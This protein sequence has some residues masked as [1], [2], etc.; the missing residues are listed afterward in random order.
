[1]VASIGATALAAVAAAASS[2]ACAAIVAGRT[3]T[4][5]SVSDSGAA[6]YTIP[7]WSPPGVGDVQLNLGLTYNSRNPNSV[8]GMGWSI[9]GLS[10]ITRCNKT[11]AQDGAPQ[12][13][14]LTMADRFCLDGQQLKL[15]SASGTYGQAGSTYATEIE[16]FAKIV[17]NSASGNGPASFTVITKNGL[18]YEYGSTLDSQIKPGGGAT[19]RTWA[20]SQIHDRVGTYGNRISFT[21]TNETTN[22]TYRIASITYPTTAS[23]Q[24]PFYEV[25]FTYVTNPASN[26]PLSYASGFFS[27]EPKRLTTIT[28]KNFGSSTPTK[29][30][31]LGYNIGTVTNRARLNSIQECSATNCLPATTIAYQ[32]G[33]PG[34]STT[35]GNTGVTTSTAIGVNPI[36]IDLNGD[37]LMDLL[38]P[39]VQTSTTSRWWA[40]QKWTRFLGQFPRSG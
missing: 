35:L 37:G 7:L 21:Y 27:R 13:V 38:Y 24:G 3:P 16:T 39:K 20:L 11:W 40:T 36:P 8:L 34:W 29:R 14:L 30:Y 25:G 9:S 19:I 17:A 22:N 32:D 18:V 15:T 31:D 33:S 1:L 10:A 12:R 26:I 5:F 23:G 28:I 6:S 4:T 2:D